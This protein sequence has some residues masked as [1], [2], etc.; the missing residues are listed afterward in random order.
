MNVG[1]D[2]EHAINDQ[3]MIAG[4]A[5]SRINWNEHVFVYTPECGMADIDTLYGES[6]FSTARGISDPGQVVDWSSRFVLAEQHAL[7]WSAQ[8]GMQEFG[9]QFPPYSSEYIYVYDIN[10]QGQVVG[11]TIS[12]SHGHRLLWSPASGVQKLDDLVINTGRAMPWQT[13][14]AFAINEVGQIG[15]S[16]RHEGRSFAILLTPV[17]ESSSVALLLGGLALVDLQL[18]RKAGAST[19]NTQLQA[20]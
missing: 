7:V 20:A 9:H 13:P 15:P 14:P 16:A 12:F 17:P 11:A 3:G 19:R 2:A 18:R 5:K 4:G 8:G 10:N 6:D 1:F